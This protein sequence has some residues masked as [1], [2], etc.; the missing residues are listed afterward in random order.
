MNPR[1]ITTVC[2][3]VNFEELTL[4]DPNL[5]R[6]TL[7]LECRLADA[8]GSFYP[9]EAVLAE[10]VSISLHINLRALGVQSYRQS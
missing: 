6:L 9:G 10:T 2:S 1:E 3:A 5:D 7:S 4:T 8:A